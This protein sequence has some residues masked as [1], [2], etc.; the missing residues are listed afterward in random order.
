MAAKET[1]K[2]NKAAETKKK[3]LSKK[4]RDFAKEYSRTG[5]GTKAALK[6]YETTNENVA[7]NIASENIRKPKVREFLAQE[8][9][10]AP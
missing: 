5:N 10:A 1:Q 2:K 4:E 6:V 9:A 8:A 7:A 3:R